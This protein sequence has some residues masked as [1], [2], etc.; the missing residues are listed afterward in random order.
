MQDTELRSYSLLAEGATFSRESRPAATARTLCLTQSV[1]ADIANPAHTD[2]AR[3]KSRPE[4]WTKG[5]TWAKVLVSGDAAQLQQVSRL[6]SHSWHACVQLAVSRPPVQV[7]QY[8]DAGVVQQHISAVYPLEK[9][10]DALA[11]VAQGH[12]RGKVCI[13]LEAED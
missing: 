3:Q 5:R 6:S 2:E 1:L 13:S 11:S 4:I 9:A 8:L 10:A 12:T 7:A